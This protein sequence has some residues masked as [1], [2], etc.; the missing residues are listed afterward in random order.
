MALQSGWT[1]AR[2]RAFE[3]QLVRI[4][5]GPGDF[6]LAPATPGEAATYWDSL[7]PA[8]PQVPRHDSTTRLMFDVTRVTVNEANRIG[9]KAAN[10]GELYPIRTLTGA[11]VPLPDQPLAIPFAHY[12]DHVQSSGAEPLIEALLRDVAAGSIAPAALEERLFAIRWT[13]YRAP[14]ADALLATLEP[15]LAAQWPAGTKLRFRSS[16]N[17]EDLAD[18]TGA[19]LYTSA[20]AAVD[21]GR[22]E[23]GS[24]IK[25]VW[26]SVWNAQAF[27][28]RDFYRVDQRQ[29]RMGIL[30][31]PAQ[32]DELANGVALTINE[33]SQLRPAY[34]I[35]AQVGDV[36]VTNPTADAAPEQ[37]LYYTWYEEPEY[38]V[39][40]RSS[41]MGWTVNWPSATALLTRPELDELADY[42]YVIHA[43]IRSRYPGSAVDVEWKLMPDRKLLIKQAR[44]FRRRTVE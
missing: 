1:D 44:P 3:D 39:I 28:E 10:L 4:E 23:L 42:L 9:A 2:L 12:A 8:A 16:T 20:A 18:F 22:A 38:E 29:V 27:I 17:V 34:Y 33:F 21:G 7:R 19:G 26:A 11:R 30:V 25:T 5:V 6:T 43:R 13:L 14:I 35:N 41:L 15:I 36:S 40:T 32:A 24:A 31:H 37:I